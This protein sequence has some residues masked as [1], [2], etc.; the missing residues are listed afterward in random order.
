MNVTKKYGIYIVIFFILVLVLLVK[1]CGSRR[2][3]QNLPNI[4]WRSTDARSITNFAVAQNNNSLRVRFSLV[5]ESHKYVSVDG[6]VSV[7]IL[8][9][10]G[11]I[12]FLESFP[13]KK[14]DFKLRT[15]I[16]TKQKFLAYS[17]DI[18]KSKINKSASQNGT[19]HLLFEMKD[20]TLE[21]ST[22]ITGLS[23][24]TDEEL[25]KINDERFSQSSVRVGQKLKRGNFEVNVLRIGFFKPFGS[26]NTYFRVDLYAKNIGNTSDYFSPSDIILTDDTGGTHQVVDS[27]GFNSF[28]ELKPGQY[29]KGF[30]IFD[31][32]P[33]TTQSIK[34][35]FY[36]GQEVN[37]APYSF[38][39][40][41]PLI[42]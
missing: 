29:E 2:A 26:K 21:A 18:P 36:L 19:I 24:Y 14:D 33:Q 20:R 39:Y 28:S 5:D 17:F 13:V 41:I 6:V 23:T 11:D 31:N 10:Y 15:F 27:E 9:E 3:P 22:V 40:N 30:L 37:G 16:L 8:D 38:E 32:V 1:G 4:D 12:L 7:E 35:S 25:M 42:K 34:L